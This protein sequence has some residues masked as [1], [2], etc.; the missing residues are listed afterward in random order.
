M[1]KSITYKEAGVNID[2]ADQLIDNISSAVQKT[3]RAEVL[4]HLGGY[5]GLFSLDLKKFKDPVLV[6]TTDGVG[7]KLKIAFELQKYDSVGQDLVAMCVNDLICCGAEPLFFLD[8][9][10][11]GKLEL[12]GA[13]QVIR[14]IA[15]ALLPIRCSLIGGET[16]EMPGFYSKGEFDLAGFAVGA[17]NRDQIID[18]ASI[19]PGDKIIGLHSSGVHSNGF[20]LVRKILSE[21]GLN[22]QSVVDGLE[23]PI[24]E[25]LLTPTKIYVNPVLELLQKFTLLG[26]AHITGGGL[27]ENVPRILPSNCAALFDRASIQTPAIFGVL[28]KLGNVPEK[29][30]WRVFNMGIGLVLVVRASEEKEILKHL[31]SSGWD[32]SAIGKIVDRSLNHQEVSFA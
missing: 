10:A 26:I 15:Q 30:M 8:Y 19:K 12:K 1:T 6:S 14:G 24:G 31:L 22:A 13:E 29:E 2:E 11:T 17:V 21:N 23:K 9:F 32:A 27:I 7:T 25:V 5:A 28:Q 4:S 20:S 16:A 3:K 18:G